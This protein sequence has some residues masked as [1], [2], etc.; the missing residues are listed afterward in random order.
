[1]LG[2][3][4]RDQDAGPIGDGVPKK[5][6]QVGRRVGETIQTDPENDDA[7]GGQAEGVSSKKELRIAGAGHG[8]TVL[9]ECAR[10]GGL[11]IGSLESR[12]LR[13][14][15]RNTLQTGSATSCCRVLRL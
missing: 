8:D 11:R 2:H 15:C 1:M 6:A 4:N 5:R 14:L 9:V 7:G 10:S 3:E 12:A 13:G